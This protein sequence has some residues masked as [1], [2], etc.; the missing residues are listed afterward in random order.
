MNSKYCVIYIKDF[1]S[2][3][4]ITL[5][6]NTSVQLFQKEKRLFRQLFYI[7]NYTLCKNKNTPEYIA[8]GA[9]I[10]SPTKNTQFSLYTTEGG[11][12]YKF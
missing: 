4:R 7:L 5:P 3:L 10:H 8:N 1:V 11:F 2:S 9:F 12:N 6:V